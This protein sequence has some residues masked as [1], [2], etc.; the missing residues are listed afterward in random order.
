M[1]KL[2]ILLL[3]II[4]GA[5]PTAFATSAMFS[6]VSE[7]EWYYEAVEN[8]AELGIVEGYEDDTYLPSN[9]VN[10]AEM[11][12]MFNRL[13]DA[14]NNGCL[15]IYDEADEAKYEESGGFTGYDRLAPDGFYLNGYEIES[16]ISCE[17]GFITSMWD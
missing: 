11:A 12:V 13:V 16:G 17:D 9:N 6:D 8:L 10:R 5:V 7:G 15:Y 1:K 4:F 3:G 14:I 2:H